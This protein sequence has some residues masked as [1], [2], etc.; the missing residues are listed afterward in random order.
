M[1]G[2]GFWEVFFQSFDHLGMR[3]FRF[4]IGKVCPFM[5]IVLVIVKFFAAVCVTDVAPTPVSDGMVVLPQ[6]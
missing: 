5:G 1:W 3:Q 2:I 4:F 6:R